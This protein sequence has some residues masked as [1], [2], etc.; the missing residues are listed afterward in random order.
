[1]I[2][3]DANP[4]RFGKD[5]MVLGNNIYL[6]AIADAERAA[7]IDIGMLPGM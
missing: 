4:G 5:N 1:M 3:I 2:G 6:A 7:T